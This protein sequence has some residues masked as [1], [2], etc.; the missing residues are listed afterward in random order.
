MICRR[1]RTKFS[2]G[3]PFCPQCTAEDAY[4][5]GED[6]M[7]KIT[8]HGGV[9]DKDAGPEPGVAHADDVEAASVE[10]ETP[11]RPATDAKK[12]SAKKATAAKKTTG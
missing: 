11:A 9:T 1:C 8:R 10:D 4:P 6:D 2:V 3:A 7:A 5:E 12:A